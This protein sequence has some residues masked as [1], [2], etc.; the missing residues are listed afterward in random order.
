M[1][2]L[3][4]SYYFPPDSR[5]GAEISAY[6]V[7][8]ELVKDGHE[9]HVLTREADDQYDDVF[10]VHPELRPSELPKELVARSTKQHVERLLD[11][12][13]FDVVHAQNEYTAIGAAQACDEEDVPC[14]VSLRD[15]WLLDPLRL[16]YDFD[17]GQHSTET[18][19]LHLLHRA[20]TKFSHQG[21]RKHL[22]SPFIL[23][24]LERFRRWER[25]HIDKA[26]MLMA[27][28]NF[29][30]DLHGDVHPNVRTLYNAVDTHVFQPLAREES[31]KT[32]ILFIGRLR[33]E[34]GIGTLIE[35]M[36]AVVADRDDVVLDIIGA[37]TLPPWLRAKVQ[38][39]D[40]SEYVTCHG[41]VPFQ[42]LP[43]IYNSADV[44]VFP[45]EWQEPFGRISIEALACGTPVVTT[46]VGGI[47]EVVDD[48]ETGLLVEP[49]N[50]TALADAV[51]RLLNDPDLRETLGKNGRQHVE[52]TFSTQTIADQQLELY[53]A[54]V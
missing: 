41:R 49:G 39:H 30:R 52:D 18:G 14:L 53:E 3:F 20:W 43:G 24:Y 37:D 7:G 11:E 5:G 21:L 45:S 54:V 46:R 44:V 10:I 40:L 23:L 25:K 29:V 42:K 15:Y 51:L 22:L 13:K 4:T 27:N 19:L 32:H 35:A 28:S 2:I 16:C 48:E 50:A 1:N 36:D 38:E 9:V 17:P 33:P 47:P 6:N 26:D 34:K 12:H 31:D 8:R